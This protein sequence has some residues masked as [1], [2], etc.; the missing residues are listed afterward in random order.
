LGAGLLYRGPLDPDDPGFDESWR[1]ESVEV[2]IRVASSWDGEST[3]PCEGAVTL[4][5]PG[6]HR[7]SQAREHAGVRG[8]R[9]RVLG[10]PPKVVPPEAIGKWVPIAMYEQVTSITE[11]G[12][13][14]RVIATRKD[15][16]SMQEIEVEGDEAMDPNGTPGLIIDS[17]HRLPLP[18]I[19]NLTV[20]P[21][22]VY[23]DGQPI[24]S[25]QQIN[26]ISV[27][28]SGAVSKLNLSEPSFKI[29]SEPSFKIPEN[30]DPVW[31]FGPERRD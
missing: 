16:R 1:W 12:S 10:R 31:T 13:P 11:V 17:I 20:G 19:N 27:P 6:D 7:V 8:K 14:A 5:G 4:S 22:T 3:T 2:A 30:E 25:A 24:G 26:N 29:L 18:P 28:A 23:A 9:E 21:A 15:L